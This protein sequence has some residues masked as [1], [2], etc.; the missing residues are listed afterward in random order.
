MPLT[1]GVVLRGDR[2]SLFGR[3]PDEFQTEDTEIESETAQVLT[4]LCN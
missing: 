3:H 1:S 2:Q 4:E